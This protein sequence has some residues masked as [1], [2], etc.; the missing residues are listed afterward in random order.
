M[1]PMSCLDGRALADAKASELRA[2]LVAQTV[3]GNSIPTNV[4]SVTIM[5]ILEILDIGFFLHDMQNLNVW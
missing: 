1:A 4:P 3:G 2:Q 5:S